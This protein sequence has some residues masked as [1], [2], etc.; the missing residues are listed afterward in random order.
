MTTVRIQDNVLEIIPL[1]GQPI[2]LAIQAY[3][4]FV[5]A[6]DVSSCNSAMIYWVG[7]KID[8]PID[9]VEEG[10][11]EKL[12]KLF[13][14][15]VER[16]T[17]KEYRPFILTQEEFDALS[18][19]STSEPTID[20]KSQSPPIRWKKRTPQEAVD[21]YALWFI[22]EWNGISTDFYRPVFD[23]RKKLTFP[24][25]KNTPEGEPN[26][27]YVLDL[28]R[29]FSPQKKIHQDNWREEFETWLTFKHGACF[30]THELWKNIADVRDAIV[31]KLQ[32]GK[33]T[34]DE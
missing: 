34:Q 16:A 28:V 25:S 32:K 17:Y 2:G 7:Q 14:N 11:K 9:A 4:D 6:E 23:K 24:P 30:I 22:G 31:V 29:E 20:S 27:K 1:A 8:L 26:E 3:R 21:M 5:K 33:T 10:I 15:D 12:A 19:Y 18:E 13:M